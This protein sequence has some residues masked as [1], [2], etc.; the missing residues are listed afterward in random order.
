MQIIVQIPSTCT[1]GRA[2]GHPVILASGDRGRTS[3]E[4]LAAEASHIGDLRVWLRVPISMKS[5]R[6]IK[7]PW[8]QSWASIFICIYVHRYIHSPVNTHVKMYAYINT[9]MEKKRKKQFLST[10]NSLA[11]FTSVSPFLSCRN[12]KEAGNQVSSWLLSLS[13]YH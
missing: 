10:S 13:F 1:N 3:S 2:V 6:A 12:Y 5:G 7:N 8:H 4:K 11:M 9:H